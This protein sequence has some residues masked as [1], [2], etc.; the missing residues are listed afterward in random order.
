MTEMGFPKHIIFG[1]IVQCHKQLISDNS[2]QKNYLTLQSDSSLYFRIKKLERWSR[3]LQ[4]LT[5]FESKFELWKSKNK[6]LRKQVSK[7]EVSKRRW[8]VLENYL[9][10][11]K[12]KRKLSR[13]N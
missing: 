7:Q 13:M 9:K 8:N 10:I 2:L 11:H 3:K 12:A 6:R 1:C 4:K 5:I